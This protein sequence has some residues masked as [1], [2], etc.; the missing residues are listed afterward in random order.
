MLDTTKLKFEEVWKIVKS[1]RKSFLTEHTNPKCDDGSH[2]KLLDIDFI[3]KNTKRLAE[4]LKLN[5][6]YLINENLSDRKTLQTA[7]EMFIYLNYCPDKLF[8]LIK[9]V[10]ET[11]TTK[12]I[13]LAFTNIMKFP[14]KLVKETTMKIFLKV[15]KSLNLNHYEKIQIISKGKCFLNGTFDECKNQWDFD[16]KV[17]HDIGVTI[18]AK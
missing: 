7:S 1:I 10:L 12:D 2:E 9:H 13:I 11:G 3:Q 6:S 14:T 15:M 4:E 16:E 8:Y 18:S 17:L 5:A